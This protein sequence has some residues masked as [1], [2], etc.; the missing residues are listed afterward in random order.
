[1]LWGGSEAELMRQVRLIKL[2]RSA[3]G[4]LLRS[5]LS[6]LERSYRKARSKIV[7]GQGNTGI[8]RGL[9]E[10]L[11]VVMTGQQLLEGNVSVP[12]L[13]AMTLRALQK[14]LR[15]IPPEFK[16]DGMQEQR[17]KIPDCE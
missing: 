16:D 2:D 17:P 10:C 5:L 8:G 14:R 9:L 3:A 12:L 13:L 7:A 1:L 4:K 15:E 6:D 11:D